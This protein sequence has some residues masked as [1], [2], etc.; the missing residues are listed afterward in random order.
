MRP[1]LWMWPGMMPILHSPGVMTPG[2]FGP[3]R[4]VFEPLHVAFHRDHV[5]DRNAFGDADDEGNFRVDRFHDRVR[6]ERR[7]NVNHGR[8]R[9]GFSDRFFNR[10]EDGKIQMLG[11][12][13]SG[14]HAADHFGSVRNRLFRV[15]RPL[16]AG[17]TLANHFGI[18][19]DHDRHA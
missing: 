6:C 12:A 11:A 16:R 7:R 1:G 14:S 13:F 19:V 3:I 15:K 8:I 2:Q 4:R 17:E 9:A 18:F 10:V 5:H